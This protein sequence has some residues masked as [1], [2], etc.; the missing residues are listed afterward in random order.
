VSEPVG[1]GEHV[2]EGVVLVLGE[3][4]VLALADALELGE[5]LALGDVL[6]LADMLELG[7][8][9]VTG[10]ELQLGSGVG[11]VDALALADALE[12]G[13]TLALGDVLVCG[14]ALEL[15]MQPDVPARATPPNGPVNTANAIEASRVAIPAARPTSP[16]HCSFCQLVCR[17]RRK[18]VTIPWIVK[19][20]H[21]GS[22]VPR[23]ITSMPSIP[24]GR[25]PRQSP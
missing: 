17:D 15:G 5:V 18:I 14:D 21:P 23:V 10:V 20:V 4:D 22:Q 25:L 3:A 12:L 11:E 24:N 13:E 8:Q 19:L 7:V 2:E 16:I 1:E 9:L 6:G